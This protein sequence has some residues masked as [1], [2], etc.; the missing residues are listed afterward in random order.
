MLPSYARIH[1][2][3]RPTLLPTRYYQ[4]L[5]RQPARAAVLPPRV[6]PPFF[7]CV[8]A[9]LQDVATM[10]T[11]G[12]THDCLDMISAATIHVPRGRE[13]IVAGM[14]TR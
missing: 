12:V 5:L 1:V 2:T 7:S 9:V 13:N 10:P 4:A 6:P 14:R 3:Q 11:P 8:R